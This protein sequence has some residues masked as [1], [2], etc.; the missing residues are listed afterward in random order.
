MTGLSGAANLEEALRDSNIVVIPAG[1]PRK[2]GMCVP[3]AA[4]VLRNIG[5]SCLPRLFFFFFFF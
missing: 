5:A 2:P 1:V 4:C 3:R